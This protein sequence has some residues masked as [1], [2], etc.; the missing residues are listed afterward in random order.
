MLCFA[1][2][3]LKGSVFWALEMLKFF[4]SNVEDTFSKEKFN[5]DFRGYKLK[6]SLNEGQSRAHYPI[7][8]PVGFSFGIFQQ[9]H[10]T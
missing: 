6:G 8:T 2:L 10:M 4:I 7:G 3:T 1:L 5:Y 9:L